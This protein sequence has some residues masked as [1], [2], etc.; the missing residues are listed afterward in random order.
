KLGHAPCT[1]Q[2]VIELLKFY[3]IKP[4]SKN[5]VVLGRSLVIG[6]PVSMMLL[7]MNATVTV[8]HSKTEN[9]EAI[10]SKA[11]ILI[12]ATG[13]ME[14]VNKYFVNKNQTVID[15]GISWNE[16]KQKLCG[17]VLFE[18]VE[19]LVKD[20]TPVPGGVGS[21]TTSILINHVIESCKRSA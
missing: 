5:V 14:S 10:A 9:I 2:S 18:E 8:C 12:C 6:K 17:D 20:I 3:D 21:L 13:K 4:A 1:A 19:P 15:V 7:N 11:D 16:K